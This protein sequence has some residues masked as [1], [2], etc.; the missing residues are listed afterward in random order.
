MSFF[1]KSRQLGIDQQ[2]RNLRKSDI[3]HSL[4]TIPDPSTLESDPGKKI[5]EISFS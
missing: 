2:S 1:A 3:R 4:K 5:G